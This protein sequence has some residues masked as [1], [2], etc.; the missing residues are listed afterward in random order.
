MQVPYAL[1]TA[2][3]CE[4]GLKWDEVLETGR[5]PLQGT[6]RLLEAFATFDDHA[7]DHMTTLVM[8]VLKARDGVVKKL[9]QITR[10]V[11]ATMDAYCKHKA[12]QL[13]GLAKCVLQDLVTKVALCDESEA[14]Y[15]DQAVAALGGVGGFD[16]VF[17]FRR[18]KPTPGGLQHEPRFHQVS[19]GQH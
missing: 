16:T 6:E 15:I 10:V 12:G 19:V 3:P 2:E 8:E 11:V 9:L 14:Y 13:G 4:G 1:I 18:P 7:R 17:F 5:F